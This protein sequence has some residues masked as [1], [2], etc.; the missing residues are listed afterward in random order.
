MCK[1]EAID[2]LHYFPIVT[3]TSMLI[4]HYRAN[5]LNGKRKA[6]IRYQTA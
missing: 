6:D 3:I 2:F 1:N 5:A 4:I